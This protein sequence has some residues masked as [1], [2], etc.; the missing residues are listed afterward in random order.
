MNTVTYGTA[1]APFL[2]I[3][4][5][6]QLA[7]DFEGTHPRAGTVTAQDFYVDDL[8]TGVSSVQELLQTKAQVTDILKTA[9]FQLTKFYSNASLGQD[10][11]QGNYGFTNTRILELLWQ[12]NSD[13]LRYQAS[14]SMI[15][16]IICKRTILS[17]ITQIFDPL[18]LIRPIIIKAKILLQSLWQLKMDWDTAVSETFQMIWSFYYQQLHL[19]NQMTI[20]RHAIVHNPNDIQLHGFCYASQTAYGACIYICSVDHRPIWID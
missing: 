12:P 19:I 7:Y 17:L 6:Q 20:P 18:G 13:L 4:C 9:G 11:H 5:L 2:A 15:P 10:K 8:I 3:R 14:E 16:E 1:A